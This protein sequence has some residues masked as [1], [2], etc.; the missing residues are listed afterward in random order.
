MNSELFFHIAKGDR[1]QQ[2]LLMVIPWDMQHL[3]F[4]LD[5]MSCVTDITAIAQKRQYKEMK[6]VMAGLSLLFFAL[7]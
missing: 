5:K 7:L 3:F 4:S 2:D 1:A 6:V